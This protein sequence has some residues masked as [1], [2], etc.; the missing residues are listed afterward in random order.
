[1]PVACVLTVEQIPQPSIVGFPL[2]AT[3]CGQHGEHKHKR[4]KSLRAYE[5]RGCKKYY[6][7]HQ[8]LKL[9]FILPITTPPQSLYTKAS[10]H[11]M[12]SGSESTR[13]PFMC[14]PAHTIKPGPK[15]K[16]RSGII[17]IK[18]AC[19]RE[20]PGPRSQGGVRINTTNHHD[21]FF[22][23]RLSFHPH[24]FFAFFTSTGT[25][26]SSLRRKKKRKRQPHDPFTYSRLLRRRCRRSTGRHAPLSHIPAHPRATPKHALLQ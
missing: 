26:F 5:R 14:H 22:F 13:V 1:M 8:A 11:T 20:I 19:K 10:L 24:F 12:L 25:G 17:P 7:A 16:K 18:V 2:T 6:T 23:R 21:H 9:L 15:K 3:H 4:R